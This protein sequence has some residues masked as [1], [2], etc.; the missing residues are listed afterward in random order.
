MQALVI[1]LYSLSMVVSAAGVL[2]PFLRVRHRVQ[3][4]IRAEAYERSLTRRKYRAMD[5]ASTDKERRVAYDAYREA[6]D[7]PFENGPE[8]VRE[9]SE[10]Y[11]MKGGSPKSEAYA[12]AK[13]RA[14]GL[15]AVVAGLILSGI[16]SILSVTVLP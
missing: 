10:G 4:A 7:A 14:A 6:M 11:V 5:A 13:S 8:T 16:A 9:L 3:K 15:G 2:V 1:T 12:E